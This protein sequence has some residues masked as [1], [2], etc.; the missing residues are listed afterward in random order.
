MTLLI[1]FCPS[2]LKCF[3]HVK[4][5]LVK[6]QFYASFIFVVLRIIF[7][8]CPLMLYIILQCIII[9]IINTTTKLKNTYRCNICENRRHT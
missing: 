3:H 1:F 5:V 6:R 8:Y 2:V 9:V 4:D 7:I